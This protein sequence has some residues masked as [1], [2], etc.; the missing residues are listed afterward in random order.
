MTFMKENKQKINHFIIN[1]SAYLSGRQ[2]LYTDKAHEE[3]PFA[4]R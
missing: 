3:W 4:H 1:Q 2:N